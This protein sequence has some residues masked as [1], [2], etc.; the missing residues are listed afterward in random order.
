MKGVGSRKQPL[1]VTAQFQQSL[2]SLMVTLNQANPF[3]IR[4]IKSNANKVSIHL[5]IS[6]INIVL[7]YSVYANVSFNVTVKNKLHKYQAKIKLC[8]DAIFKMFRAIY[9]LFAYLL[10]P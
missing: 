8:S 10:L 6:V 4:C 9:L 5:N 2:Q 7:A 3:F 1:T